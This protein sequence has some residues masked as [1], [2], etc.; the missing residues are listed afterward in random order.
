[1]SQDKAL[2]RALEMAVEMERRGYDFYK[3]CAAKSGDALGKKVFEAL[4]EDENRHIG[5]INCYCAEVA[6]RSE[7]PRLCDAISPH[8]PIKMR[9]IFGKREVELLKNV[10]PDTD[11]LRAYEIAM[12]MENDGY[13]FYKKSLTETADANA[14]DLYE[15]L[16]LEEKSHFDLISSTYELMKNPAG[17]FIKDEKPIVEG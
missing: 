14:K 12:K 5:A 9:V 17:W 10:A 13:G 2:V 6:D 4:A 16:L 8:K 3:K 15:F 1:M 7:T 11:E